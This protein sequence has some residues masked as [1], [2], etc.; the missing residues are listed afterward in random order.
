MYSVFP[1]YFTGF[2]RARTDKL[3]FDGL[4]IRSCAAPE[5]QR[6]KRK[7]LRKDKVMKVFEAEK[8]TSP[9]R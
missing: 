8:G 9:E 5:R 4:M 1:K 7:W 2:R 3:S 6:E